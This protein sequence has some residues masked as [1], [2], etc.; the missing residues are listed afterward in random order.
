L[1]VLTILLPRAGK[2]PVDF[3]YFRSLHYVLLHL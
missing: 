2:V 3:E 1:L